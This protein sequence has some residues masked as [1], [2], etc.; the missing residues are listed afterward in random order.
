[1]LAPARLVGWF[2][3]DGKV[4]DVVTG[5]TGRLTGG[6][7]FGQMAGRSGVLLDGRTGGVVVPDSAAYA[8]GGSFSIAV[9]AFA[10]QAPFGGSS[11]QG[12]LVFRGDDRSACDNYAICLGTDGYY[13]FMI[14]AV[15][16]SRALLRAPAKTGQWERLLATF[17]VRTTHM[18]LS[19]DGYLVAEQ[20]VPITPFTQMVPDLDPGVSFGNVQ[21]P[22]KG[23]H[24]QP[25]N[26]FL[27][28]VR[29]FDEAVLWDASLVNPQPRADRR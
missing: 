1:M 13:T 3:L 11:P 6:A 24:W 18:T 8:L 5:A 9:E 15:D 10:R 26:G 22:E 20:W 25:Y 4:A 28:D 21:A 12:Q 14:D 7:G 23:R 29:F 16:G 19:I 2:P 27:R 17:D